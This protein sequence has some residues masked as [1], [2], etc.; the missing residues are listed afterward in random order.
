[1]EFIIKIK[2]YFLIPLG[3]GKMMGRIVIIFV[4]L[5]AFM[6]VICKVLKFICPCSQNS[7]KQTLAGFFSL[8]SLHSCFQVPHP[9]KQA[10]L[11]DRASSDNERSPGELSIGNNE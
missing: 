10:T 2:E 4:F 11:D 9:T 5:K 8:L 7:R 3:K 1:M 6:M